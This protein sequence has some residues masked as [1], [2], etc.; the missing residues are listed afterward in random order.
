MCER[1][2]G[3][4][5]L[6]E[7]P[8]DC[9]VSLSTDD[10]APS[11]AVRYPDT[12]PPRCGEAQPTRPG[13]PRGPRAGGGPGGCRVMDDAGMRGA[14]RDTTATR[15][16]ASPAAETDA[17]RVAA[18]TSRASALSSSELSRDPRVRRDS[19]FA[20]RGAAAARCSV[21]VA[22]R[23]RCCRSTSGFAA[24]RKSTSCRKHRVDDDDDSVRGRHPVA[25]S[26]TSLQQRLSERYLTLRAEICRRHAPSPSR[27]LAFREMGSLFRV[28]VRIVRF[29]G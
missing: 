4:E 26:A 11:S 2:V 6:R 1:S 9:V 17:G 29:G 24:D 5:H 10:V 12:L 27:G 19:M 3:R 15:C 7:S 13:V 21:D 14:G 25:V 8:V 20:P 16:S 22:R 23:C 18:D 28:I